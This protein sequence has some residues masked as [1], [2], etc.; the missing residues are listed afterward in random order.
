MGEVGLS[1]GEP[2]LSLPSNGEQIGEHT[3]GLP[4]EPVGEVITMGLRGMGISCGPAGRGLMGL[5]GLTGG[6]PGT[7]VCRDWEKQD[8]IDSLRS[9][10]VQQL[11]MLWGYFSNH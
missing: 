1:V 4:S 2:S 3:L 10:E 6:L 5:W 9:S 8:M 11:S 7:S